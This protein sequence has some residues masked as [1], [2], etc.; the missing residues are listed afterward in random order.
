MLSGTKFGSTGAI[1]HVGSTECIVDTQTDTQ[2]E[3]TT[4]DHEAG[5]FKVTVNVTD[6]GLASG[7]FTHTYSLSVNSVS[8]DS[9]KL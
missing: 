8:P 3:C 1:V 9:G 4:E 6:R 5:T 7:S 2:I